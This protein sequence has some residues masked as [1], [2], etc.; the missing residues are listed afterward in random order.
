MRNPEFFSGQDLFW[1]L[2]NRAQKEHRVCWVL[3]TGKSWEA[4]TLQGASFIHSFQEPEIVTSL[5]GKS[6]RL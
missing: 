4:E 6:V 5:I 3:R 2:Q 1:W